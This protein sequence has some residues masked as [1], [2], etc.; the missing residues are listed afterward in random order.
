MKTLLCLIAVT[1]FALAQPRVQ[2]VEVEPGVKLEVLDWGGSGPPLVLLAGYNTAHVYDDFAPKLTDR[3]H[4]YGITRRG[5]GESSA[6][7]SG[8]ST[9]RSA[10]DVLRVIQTLGLQKPILAGVGFAGGDLTVLGAREDI[11][12]LIYF[13]SAQ[14]PTLR[15]PPPAGARE[16]LPVSIREPMRTEPAD[17]GSFAAYRAWQKRTAGVV[18]PESELRQIYAANA[19]GSVGR[20][21]VDPR[22]REAIFRES[23]KPDYER[24]R[25]PVLAFYRTPTTMAEAV[26]KYRPANESETAALRQ[27]I[28]Y[29]RQMI[30]KF[31]EG[32]VNGVPWAQVVEMPG[33]NLYMFL[34]HEEEVL[35]QMRAFLDRVSKE[36]R[37]AGERLQQQEPGKSQAGGEH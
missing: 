20:V 14:D 21:L 17:T 16:Q 24:V 12:P 5:Y 8:Y 27:Y 32:L 4:V 10:A 35:R 33:A 25:V 37:F 23:V 9:A 15:M 29:S 6:P 36:E 22:V 30:E 26:R 11:G 34:S 13:D 2:M 7:A 19:D 18:F 1:T 31:R 28:G 3:Y